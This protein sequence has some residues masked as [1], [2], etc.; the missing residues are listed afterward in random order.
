MKSAIVTR[1]LVLAAAAAAPALAA[2]VNV[3]ELR[4]VVAMVHASRPDIALGDPIS[5]RVRM[6]TQV[7]ESH[8]V[9]PDLREYEYVEAHGNRITV[10]VGA[11][12]LL[13][14]QVPALQLSML[15]HPVQ[16]YSLTG[17]TQS[18]RELKVTLSLSND[19]ANAAIGDPV[20]LQL[21]DYRFAD[22]T[23]WENGVL[24]VL[25]QL[26]SMIEVQDN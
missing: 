12:R 11:E 14:A 18:G 26:K 8:F 21:H 10:T 9:D 4:G 6:K 19:Q 13:L 3:V 2:D 22:V 25:G 24:T 16:T 1:V 17:F 15:S 5:V 7:L 23:V 20:P